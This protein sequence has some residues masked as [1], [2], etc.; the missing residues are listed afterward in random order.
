MQQLN[1]GYK[2]IALALPEAF[3]CT[4]NDLPL[5][6]VL[7]WFEQKAVAILLALFSLNVQNITIGPRVPEFLSPG[8]VE[9]LQKTFGL[10][11]ISGDAK[12]DLAKML[13]SK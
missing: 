3:Q 4:V 12:A 10:K 5:S 11:L 8:V 6:I 1:L 7:S 2:K 9:V 13:E